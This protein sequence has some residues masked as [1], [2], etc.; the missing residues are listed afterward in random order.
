VVVSA[1]RDVD[2]RAH[3]P[4]INGA[5][6]NN[7]LAVPPGPVPNRSVRTDAQIGA[8]ITAANQVYFPH[9]I[10]FVLNGAVDRAGVRN[11]ASQGFVN[12][13]NAEFGQMM[14]TNRANNMVNM[15]FVPQ[16]GAAAEINDVHGSASSVRTAPTTFGSLI[17]DQAAAT[18]HVIAHELGHVLNLINDPGAA[19]PFIHADA[20]RQGGPAGTGRQVRHDIITRRRLMFS[21]VD[22]PANGGM[23]YRDDVGYGADSPG[24][25]LTVKQLNADRTDMEA[26]EVRRNAARI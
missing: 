8:M 14:A 2:V 17:S 25:L 24:D 4:Q 12:D 6:V 10:R 9:G 22:F 16:I 20:V 7:P 18:G 21:T 5:A 26:Q 23:A 1:L 13:Q 3:V 19:N 15:Y 11:F